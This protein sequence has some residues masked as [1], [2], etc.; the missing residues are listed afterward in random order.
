[1][2]SSLRHIAGLV[3]LFIITS[4]AH[5]HFIFVS[6]GPFAEGGRYAEVYF[7]AEAEAGDPHFVEKIKH[8]QLWFQTKKSIWKVNGN[9]TLTNSEPVILEWNNCLIYT[10]PLPRD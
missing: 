6:I 5:A 1:M 4:P 7:S 2:L 9:K 3:V 10:S 8:T